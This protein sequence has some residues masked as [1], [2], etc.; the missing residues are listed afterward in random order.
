M[1]S[2]PTPLVS[3]RR[4]LTLHNGLWQSSHRYAQLPNQSP[5][6]SEFRPM[7]GTKIKPSTTRHT[8]APVGPAYTSPQVRHSNRKMKTAITKRQAAATHHQGRNQTREKG[9]PDD[10]CSCSLTCAQCHTKRAG[11]V[12]A[13]T[14]TGQKHQAPTRD[15]HSLR[16]QWSPTPLTPAYPS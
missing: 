10:H 11:D 1:N 7:Q 16:R 12:Q 15:H 8:H 14:F 2:V 3:L 13:R 9:D 4:A 5:S 6:T